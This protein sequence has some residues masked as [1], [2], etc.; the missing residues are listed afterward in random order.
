MISSAKISSPYVT[1]SRPMANNNKDI[2]SNIDKV[3]RTKVKV[4]MI[5]FTHVYYSHDRHRLP[6]WT[7]KLHIC[8][9]ASRRQWMRENHFKQNCTWFDQLHSIL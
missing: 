8:E 3:H 6:N 1:D 5:D 9:Q 2:D 7:R 4:Y